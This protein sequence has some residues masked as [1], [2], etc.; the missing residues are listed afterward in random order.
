VDI[1]VK[2]LYWRALLPAQIQISVATLVVWLAM[3][4]WGSVLAWLSIARYL[5]Y[6]AGMLD[7]GN[8]S[9]AIGS[10]QRE[11]PLVFTFTDGSMSRLALHVEL[12]Y[13]VLA[14]PYKF[15]PDPRLLLLLQAGLFAFGALPVYRMALRHSGNSFVA[16]CLVLIYLW[17]PTAQTSVLFDFHGDTLALPLLLFAL[18]ALDRSA[19]WWYW[20]WIVLALSCKFYVAVPVALLGFV[21]WQKYDSRRVAVFTAVAGVLY[22]IVAFFVIRPSFTTMQ[23]A[24]AHRGLN[25]LS[26]YFGDIQSILTSWPQRLASAI[27]V[28]GPGLFL[29]RRSWVWLIPALPIAAAALLSTGPAASYDFRYHHYAI[30]VPFVMMAMIKG[31]TRRVPQQRSRLYRSSRNISTE[32]SVVATCGVVLIFTTI[33]VDTPLSPQFW[34]ASPG[35]GLNEW[36]YGITSRDKLKDDWL[37]ASVRPNAPIAASTFLAPHV[38]NRDTLYLSRYPDESEATRLASY[39][40]TLDSVIVDALFDWAKILDNGNI[41]GG[42]AY[43]RSAIQ[44][45]MQTPEWGL[46]SARD[47]LL[48]F[49]RQPAP[50]A[51]LYQHIHKVNDSSPARAQIGDMMELIDGLVQH[52][53]GRRYRV[54]FR[55][56]ATRDLDGEH[57]VAVSTLSETS[58]AR[59]VHLPS[60][61]LTPV[62]TWR[63]GEVWEEQFEVEL[64][65]TIPSGQYTW[66]TGWYDTRHPFAAHTDARS[67]VDAEVLVTT[68]DVQ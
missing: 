48:R 7:L 54:T 59:F 31:V 34:F 60:Y 57:L 18:D 45:V 4:T 43:D 50:N 52:V 39:L 15:W 62:Q 29:I 37:R 19:W 9:Q 68:I 8:M 28:F 5:G 24:D 53:D 2:K 35:Y 42:V 64:P 66:R 13:F 38:A 6:N 58:G 41:A 56:R 1:P 65:D 23:T 67:R 10:V 36:S 63:A 11:Q 27:V 12:F 49:D 25:Y 20:L 33:L 47:G 16:V 17:Y 3:L 46:T 40:P 44:L 22:G 51:V 14:L 26:F 32:Y 30:V 61:A 55:W 21:I